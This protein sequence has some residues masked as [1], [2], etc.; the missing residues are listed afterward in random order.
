MEVRIVER[1]HRLTW[2]EDEDGKLTRREEGE[3]YDR[4]FSSENKSE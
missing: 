1:C 3:G 4:I 2:I